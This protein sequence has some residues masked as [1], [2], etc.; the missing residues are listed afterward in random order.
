MREGQQVSNYRRFTY[1]FWVVV[2]RLGHSLFRLGQWQ[3]FKAQGK[4]SGRHRK[5]TRPIKIALDF[6]RVFVYNIYVATRVAIKKLK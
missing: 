3:S 5:E 4:I 1:R 6:I 2:S